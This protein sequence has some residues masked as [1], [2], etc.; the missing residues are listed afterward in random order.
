MVGGS[1]KD[2]KDSKY[3][4]A[5]EIVIFQPEFDEFGGE[6]RV[7]LALSREL[8]QQGKA[9]SV[10]CYWD[11][12][13][14]AK[15][16]AWPLKV[17]AL[18][19]AMNPLSKML[20]LRKCLLFL[21]KQGSPIP[22]LFNIQSALHAG[23]ALKKPYHLRIPDTY[24]LLGKPESEMKKATYLGN[25]STR[26]SDIIRHYVSGRGIRRAS[27][28]I[29]NTA[30]LRNEMQA[31][32]GRSAEVI[33]L[34]GFGDPHKYSPKRATSPIELFTVSRLQSNKR[35]DWILSALAEIERGI[36]KFPEWRLHVAGVGPEQDT[37]QKMTNE[38]GLSHVVTFHGFVSDQQL[39][40][41]YE[42]S[43]L[44]L[45]PAKQG[46]GLPG[47]EALYRKLPVVVSEDS[48]VVEI[49]EN[50]S[51]VSIARNG[52]PGFTAALKEMLLRVNHPEFFD[53]P[54]PNLPSEESW[55]R[56]VIKYCG[57]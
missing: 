18:R 33:Y 38:L 40:D 53:I 55:A 14:L 2:D 30:A 6:E 32:Y 28:F 45:M 12:I 11:Q 7:I 24:R 9:H 48:G 1:Q 5:G 47:L 27:R 31:L 20:S 57:W 54:L 52:Q 56:E 22:I 34:G 21:H 4:S 41:L 42:R 29:T 23:F 50:T 43:H 17:C 39:G 8:Y 37:L 10:L 51:W 25:L 3:P 35:I 16:A 46:Y 49:F 26:A 15:Y 19:P 36:T 44:F 13:G